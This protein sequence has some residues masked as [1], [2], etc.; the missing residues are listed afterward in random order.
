MAP[1]WLQHHMCTVCVQ[2]FL[3]ADLPVYSAR[4]HGEITQERVLLL[5]P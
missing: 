5:T 2:H 1:D 3:Y 4:D